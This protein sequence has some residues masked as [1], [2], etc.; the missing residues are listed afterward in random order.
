LSRGKTLPFGDPQRAA[1]MM[2]PDDEASFADLV[3][4]LR[5][6]NTKLL[7]AIRAM[8]PEPN[9]ETRAPHPFFGDLNCNEWAVFQRVHD[10]DHIQHAGKI[11]ANA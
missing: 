4:D 5:Q 6:T 10:E 1:G 9:I 8:P 11:L 3:E 2:R 7:T